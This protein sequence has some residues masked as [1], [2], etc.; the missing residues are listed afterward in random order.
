MSVINLFFFF[1][2]A[3]LY[4]FFSKDPEVIAEGALYLKA[5]SIFGIFMAV[6]LVC[7]GAFSGVGYSRPVFY[8]SVPLTLLRF[9]LG[10]FLLNYLGWGSFGIWFAI[11][12]STGLK[13]ALLFFTFRLGIWESRIL[14]I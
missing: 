8:I 2:A 9:P 1:E 5:V 6:E 12:L 4:G 13:G 3:G 10:W 11:S 14:K 7:E